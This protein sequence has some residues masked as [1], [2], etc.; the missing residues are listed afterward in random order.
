MC[1]RDRA[2]Y[3]AFRFEQARIQTGAVKGPPDVLMLTDL[4]DMIR[5]FRFEPRRNMPIE[6]LDWMRSVAR[7][8]P[9]AGII[10]K[11]TAALAWNQ[12]PEESRLW[13]KRLCKMVRPEECAAVK[14]A[15]VRMA[16]TDPEIRAIPWPDANSR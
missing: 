9:S 13:L 5:Y 2:S 3:L 8:Y 6:E 15:W 1:I 10:H 14:A 7:L 4:R 11:L 16:L 12:Q